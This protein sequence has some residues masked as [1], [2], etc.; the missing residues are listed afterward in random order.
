MR[1]ILT[2][3]ITLIL[4]QG[5]I[6]TESRSEEPEEVAADTLASTDYQA[7]SLMGVGLSE[8]TFTTRV[9]R[10]RQRNLDLAKANFDLYPDSLEHIIWYGRRLAYL[11]KYKE[12][13]NVYSDGLVKHPN[14]FEL[15][16]HRGH[17][18]ITIRRFDK[19]I[20]DLEEAAFHVRGIPP[21]TEPDGLPNRKNIPLST[22]QF[23]IWY[24]LGLAYYLSGDFDKAI[25]SYKKCMELSVNDDLLVA[26]TDWLY[27]TYRKIGNTELAN[28]LLEPIKNRMDIIENMDYHNR[29]LMYK[30]L[31][32]AGDLIS[33]SNT[34]NPIDNPTLG[35]GVANWLLYN[36][37]TDQ[38][39][40]VLDRILQNADWDSFGYIAAEVDR[41][42]L[43]IL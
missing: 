15:L 41:K 40:S 9:L 7:I 23:N 38:A 10:D 24:H 33:L 43:N 14:S 26:T 8:K 3:S 1:L 31:K 18:Y 25:S 11:S 20:K 30:G 16:R 36:G 32:E 12:A 13:I 27:M 5:C 2:L 28:S 29:L 6:Q 34:E 37:D 39:R 19:A 21:L 42:A 35:Y 17:R 4:I 22:V